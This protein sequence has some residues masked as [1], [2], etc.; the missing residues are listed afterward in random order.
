MRKSKSLYLL[1]ALA[2]IMGSVHAQDLT[3]GGVLTASADNASGA[4]GSEG[5][6]KVVDNDITTKFLCTYTSPLLMQLQFSAAQTVGQYTLTSGNDGPTRDPKTWKLEGSNNGSTWTVVDTRT[7]EAFPDRKQTRVFDIASAP[8]AYLYY[9]MNISANNGSTLFQLS[10]WRLLGASAASGVPSALKALAL[11]GTTVSLSWT[12]NSVNNSSFELQRSADGT[13]Y[14]TIATGATTTYMDTKA[15]INT[16]YQYRVRA[17]NKYGSTAYSTVASVTTYNSGGELLDM[18]DDGGVLTV[19]KEN[20]NVNENSPHLIDNNTGTKY[21]IPQAQLSVPADYWMMYKAVKSKLL[22]YYTITSG[23]DAEERDPKDWTLEGSNDGSTW[24]QLDKQTGQTF[25]GR[26]VTRNFYLSSSATAYQYY[27]WHV[28]AGNSTSNVPSQIAEWELYGL[29]PD[30]PLPAAGLT[31]S[32]VL[33]SSVKVTWTTSSSATVTGYELQRS[34]D[35]D[36]N[37]ETITTTAAS[38]NNYTDAGL[39]GGTRYYYRLRAK[40]GDAVSIFTNV[41]DTITVWDPELPLTPQALTAAVTSDTS[42]LLT[43]EDKSDIETGYTIE[44]STNGTSFTLIATV[45]ANVVSYE[46][47]TLTMATQY[48]YR[49]RAF[50]A[51]GTSN[52]TDVV[53][54]ITSGSNTAPTLDAISDIETCNTSVQTITIKGITAGEEAGQTVSLGVVSDN[55]NVF[56]ALSISNVVNG[57]ATI[58]YQVNGVADTAVVTVTATDNGGTLNEGV[59]TYSQSF[60]VIVSPIHVTITANPG[61]LINRYETVQLTASGAATYVWDSAH[62]IVGAQNADVLTVKPTVNTLYKAKGTDAQGCIDSASVVVKLDTDYNLKPVNVL[63]PNG[64]GK[65]DTWVIWN[66]SSFPNNKVTVFDRAGRSVFHAVNYT[67]TWNGTVNGA[68]L[69]QGTYVYV[70]E[71]GNGIEPVKGVLT[72]IRDRN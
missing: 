65:N 32:N 21:L 54:V 7:N 58:T 8:A 48:W 17:V 31:V 46:D 37:F 1:A 20:T 11:S 30:A 35:T 68:P 12:N 24:V 60:T 29:D 67:N 41:V 16:T 43:W 27:K 36:E 15:A 66:I 56:A 2:L 33:V 23:N 72:I 3:T 59:D 64:D 4:D 63:T 25:S 53:D 38:A 52:Y 55:S 40:A 70:I 39:L 61:T 62:G 57:E 6:K 45:D 50:N 51:K 13:N 28:T 22:I 71:L 69:A 42:V 9:R 34:K 47:T 10:E 19:D 5:S 49:V 44:R 18:T 14:T 26:G